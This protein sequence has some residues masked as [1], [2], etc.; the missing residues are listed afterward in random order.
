MNGNN[1]GKLAADDRRL[2]PEQWAV[3]A[4]VEADRLDHRMRV[5]LA[6]G[7]DGRDG[8]ASSLADHRMRSKEA[9]EHHLAATRQA[10][11]RPP[12]RWRRRPRERWRGSQVEQAY[13]SMHAAKVFLVDLLPDAEVD[14]LR[15]DVSARMGVV[16]DRADPRRIEA[17]KSLQSEDSMVRRIALKQ[18][19]ETAYDA[20]DE[21]YTRLRD[22]RNIM[23]R[24]AALVALFLVAMLSIVWQ[25]PKALPLCFNPSVSNAAGAEQEAGRVCPSGDRQN[26]SR[27]DLP[28]VAGLGA[29]GGG[30]AALL[31][32]RNLRGT[33]TPYSIPVALAL[34]KVPAGALTAV[35]GILLLGGEFAPGFSNLDSQRQILA[36]ALVFGYAQQAITGLVDNR[37]QSILDKIPSKDPEARA[38]EPSVA[39][40]RSPNGVVDRGERAI[41]TAHAEEAT[42]DRPA[43]HRRRAV[44]RR[45]R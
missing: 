26:P 7:A 33:S 18:A 41:G 12:R 37:A 43:P 42:G 21:E 8:P 38:P 13:R 10:C 25:E 23:L 9:V 31:A 36:Y 16:L 30:L 45:L 35:A 3:Q 17:E 11:E 4:A 22:F 15:P 32:I 40:P 2:W 20:S 28:I 27:G 44:G 39:Q 24:T 6:N 5:A 1:S 29:I 14:A 34:L 19:M